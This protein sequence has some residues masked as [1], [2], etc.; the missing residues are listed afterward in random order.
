M[1][2]Q[3]GDILPIVLVILLVA[4]GVWTFFYVR[5]HHRDRGSTQTAATSTKSTASTPLSS[6]SDNQSLDSDLNNINSGLNQSN[7][8]L[9]NSNNALNDQQL[10]V[11]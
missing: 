4:F 3:Q 8:D 5:D 7:Q 1:R 9:K 2:R 11:N 10:P 6:G